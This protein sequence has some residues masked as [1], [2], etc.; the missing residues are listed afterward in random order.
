M[1]HNLGGIPRF[2]DMKKQLV[3]RGRITGHLSNM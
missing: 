2:I 1:I 3:K